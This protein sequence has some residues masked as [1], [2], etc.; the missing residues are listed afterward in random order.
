MTNK[1]TVREFCKI[2]LGKET[3]QTKP[4]RKDYTCDLSKKDFDSLKDIKEK[5]TDF[6]KW[7]YETQE[8]DKKPPELVR[9]KNSKTLQIRNYVG[10][11]KLPDSGKVLE[12]LPKVRI[13]P[14]DNEKDPNKP[15]EKQKLIEMICTTITP[16]ISDNS[17][18]D[19]NKD[20]LMEYLIAWFL[21]HMGQLL[22]RGVKQNYISVKENALFIKGK[23]L[24]AQDIKYNSAMRHRTYI[25]YEDYTPD[26]LE[27][28]L[29]H[30]ALWACVKH[31]DNPDNKTL[32]NRYCHMFDSIGKSTNLNDFNQWHDNPTYPEYQNIKPI[33]EIILR[34]IQPFMSDGKNKAPAILFPMEIVYEKY[35]AHCLKQHATYYNIK[36]QPKSKRL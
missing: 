36:T 23:I 24:F 6:L 16:R 1:I 18:F 13:V 20:D 21:H 2:S 17:D 3:V 25:E 31:S 22:K 19:D 11:I 10:M 15:S 4:Q 32:A 8:T 26:C 28:R 7:Y 34:G 5:T 12:I 29:L 14:E 27:N 35:I 9:L 33:T 30:S